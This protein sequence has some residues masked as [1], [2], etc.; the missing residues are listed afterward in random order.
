MTPKYIG[1]LGSL[2][3]EA[4]TRLWFGLNRHEMFSGLGRLVTFAKGEIVAQAG[5][6]PACCYYVLEGRMMAFEYTT[7]TGERYYN[8]NEAGSLVMEANILL[9][10]DTPVSFV[11]ITEVKAR[12]ITREELIGALKADGDLALEI[13]TSLSYKFMAAMDQ[14]REATQ[15]NVSWKVCNLLLTFAQRYGVP[16]DGKVLIK[17]KI[18]QQMMANLLGV[19]R[20]TMVRAIKELRELGMIEQVN[21]FYCI[22][23]KERMQEFMIEANAQGK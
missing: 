20:I 12:A 17:E 22:R 14:V 4:H 13:M 23:D 16:Y 15:C 1:S 18:S 21:G 5:R 19:N 10:R 6:R 3:G 9:E 2:E 8:F 7:A 11:A